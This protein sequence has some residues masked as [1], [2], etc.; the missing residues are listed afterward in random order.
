MTSTTGVRDAVR[1]ACDATAWAGPA[2]VATC[3]WP[4]CTCLSDQPQGNDILTAL[5]AAARAEEREACAKAAQEFR[6]GEYGRKPYALGYN[7]GAREQRDLTAHVIRA[8][9]TEEPNAQ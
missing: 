5:I 4:D 8:R 7:T 9:A 1:R 3:E 6:T 2:V